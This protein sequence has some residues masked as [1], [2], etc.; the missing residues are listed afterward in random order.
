MTDVRNEKK[1]GSRRSLRRLSVWWSNLF[2][3]LP[4]WVFASPPELPPEPPASNISGSQDQAG[5]DLFKLDL[6]HYNQASDQCKALHDETSKIIRR[7]FLTLTGTCLFCVITLAGSSDIQL[8]TAEATVKLPVLN[9]D[10]GF[11]A[12]L[13]VGP[14]VLISLTL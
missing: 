7:V 9:Y 4:D 2:D 13:I 11:E 5:V 1:M 10:M 12:F 8:L 6:D 3:R 14:I